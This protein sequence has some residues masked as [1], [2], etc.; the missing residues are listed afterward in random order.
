MR[1]KMQGSQL[2]CKVAN[3]SQNVHEQ[4]E[5]VERKKDCPLPFPAVL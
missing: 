5:V 2:T 4:V 3:K 1:L